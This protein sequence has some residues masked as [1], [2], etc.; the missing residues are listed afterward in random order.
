MIAIFV[1]NTCSRHDYEVL[2][3][4]RAGLVQCGID[5]AMPC[6]LVM[7]IISYNNIRNLAIKVQWPEKKPRKSR[8]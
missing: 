4:A 3:P 8:A 6:R 1:R 5:A 7:M 2:L